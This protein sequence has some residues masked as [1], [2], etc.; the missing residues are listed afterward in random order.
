MEMGEKTN[1]LFS[2]RAINLINK[3]T[4]KV[5]IEEIKKYK[6]DIL[7]CYHNTK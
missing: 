2:I 3:M 7:S 4:S 1:V 5:L 6:L